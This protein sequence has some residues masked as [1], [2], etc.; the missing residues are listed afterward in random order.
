M[1][2]LLPKARRPSSSAN[3]TSGKLFWLPGK[4]KGIKNFCLMLRE[5]YYG[6]TNE[7]KFI[8]WGIWYV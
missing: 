7:V 6:I 4:K 3:S 1:E 5:E 8:G 2:R